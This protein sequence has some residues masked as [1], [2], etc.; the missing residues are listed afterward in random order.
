MRL[1][2]DLPYKIPTSS[3]DQFKSNQAITIMLCAM[4]VNA[5]S[6]RPD[7][8]GQ[9]SSLS[10]TD[11]RIWARIQDQ[12]FPEPDEIDISDD[13]FDWLYDIV[14]NFDFPAHMSLWRWTL[15]DAWDMVRAQRG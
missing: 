15:L 1:R 11:S 5:K 14:S 7:A 6:M 3:R 12:M 13:A 8:G 9:T 2:L 4:A 10:R